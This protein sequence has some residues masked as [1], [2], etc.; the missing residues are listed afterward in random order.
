M[1]NQAFSY[2][3]PSDCAPSIQQQLDQHSA[4]GG[5]VMLPNGEYNIVHPVVVD[6]SSLC[7]SGEG[8]ACNTDPN[9]V[10]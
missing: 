1:M 4:H 10:F 8:W 7:L 2:V 5:L 9:G 3:H 6:A